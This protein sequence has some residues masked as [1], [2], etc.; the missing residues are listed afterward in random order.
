MCSISPDF[1]CHR[2]LLESYGQI[3][4]FPVDEMGNG[5]KLCAMHKREFLKKSGGLELLPDRGTRRKNSS[6]AKQY[7]VSSR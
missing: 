6:S 7:L 3:F 1:Y 5:L 2:C 4:R